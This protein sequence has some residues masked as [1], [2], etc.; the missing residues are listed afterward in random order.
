[1]AVQAAREALNTEQLLT[2]KVKSGS[3]G[4]LPGGSGSFDPSADRFS[5]QG[6]PR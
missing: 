5:L 6:T 1:M 2:G 3:P 4:G